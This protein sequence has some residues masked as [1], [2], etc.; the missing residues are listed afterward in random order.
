MDAVIPPEI[1]EWKD[2]MDRWG[3]KMLDAVTVVAEMAAVGFDMAPDS[4]TSRMKF[5]PHLLAPTGSD[6]SRFG[7]LGR[8]LAGFHYDLNFM[9]IHGKNRYPGLYIWTRKGRKVAV[10]VPD[11][12]LLVQVGFIRR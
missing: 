11:G 6:Y 12:C 9:T 5:G 2:V 10:K 7:D 8:V 1:P 3:G 4:F